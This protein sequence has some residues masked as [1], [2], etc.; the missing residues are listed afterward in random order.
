MNK[1]E[2]RNLNKYLLLYIIRIEHD[3]YILTS[4][5]PRGVTGLFAQKSVPPG[6]IST[7]GLFTG[8]VHPGRFAQMVKKWNKK[9]L[10]ENFKLQLIVNS[11]IFIAS[12]QIKLFSIFHI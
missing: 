12:L 1:N 5:G 11:L 9:F 2:K 6:T 4:A 10:I 7:N 3:F 8:T